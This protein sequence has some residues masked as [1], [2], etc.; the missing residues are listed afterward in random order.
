[1]L[2][3]EPILQIRI[4]YADS[5]VDS[6]K[7]V[8]VAEPVEGNGTSVSSTPPDSSEASEETQVTRN[9]ESPESPSTQNASESSPDSLVENSW[10]YKDGQLSISE[11]G[12][13]TL[14]LGDDSLPTGATARGIDVSNWQGTID[15]TKVKASGIKFVFLKVG[16]VYGK[17]DASFERNASECERLGIPYGV[18]YYTYAR[19]T[20]DA[21]RD[22]SRT[23]SWLGSHHPT[24]PVYYDVEDNYILQDPAFSK[25]KLTGIVRTFCNAVSGAGFKTG[26]YANLNWFNNYLNSSE[27]KGY[28]RWVAQY[29]Y[30]CDYKGSYSFW[31]YSASGS[32]PGISG[33][34]DMNYSY[35]NLDG[36]I[37]TS[38]PYVSYRAHVSKKGWQ[39]Y[40]T[41][42]AGTTGKG[43]P[44]EA[45][46]LKL[47]NGNSDDGIA[48]RAHVQNIGW[49]GWVSDQNSFAGTTGKSLRIEAL[50][51]K[52]T[53]SIADSYDLYYRVHAANIGWMSWT[54]NGESAGSQGYGYGV[55]A[56]QVCLAKKGEAAPTSS[57][58][59]TT[60]AFRRK[61]VSVSYRA[62]VARKGW[63]T[64]T[65]G[66][67]GTT[68][69][70]L[71]IEALQIKLQNAELSG[72]VA[73]KA[74]VQNIGWQ[75]WVTDSNKIA[76]TTGRSLR[77]EALQIK[78]TGDMAQSYDLYYRVHSAYI[79]WMAW[80]KNGESAGTQ[81]YGRGV[82]AVEIKLVK[83]GTQAP[84]SS[85]SVT[86][87]TFRR[88]S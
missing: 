62:H 21:T 48:V 70:G 28:D 86:S 26:I 9:L 84:S 53:G 76:G 72:A 35:V 65:S 7:A 64:F 43:L 57:N 60:D 78:L 56:V 36:S 51:L 75:N 49:Q 23:L 18:Y 42:I 13:A 30:R 6:V 87:D 79:G 40:T 34:I 88:K 37:P 80:A 11:N 69:I 52:L 27:L 8:T 31:Q 74:H 38:D 81:G 67:A 44:I 45:L 2:I 50:Q 19:S 17:I 25:Q 39:T 71:P 47:N 73:V 5:S 41:D 85:G 32:V 1:M 33:S 55:E 82:E 29:N 14:S 68:G 54:K 16:P 58:A 63:Q 22:A 4:A 77:I 3:A 46:Q 10:R 59:A 20:A 15:W 61:P 12:I 83:K 24:L 66:I